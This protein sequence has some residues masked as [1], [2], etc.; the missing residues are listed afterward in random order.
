MFLSSGRVLELTL[1][2][3][4]LIVKKKNYFSLRFKLSSRNNIITYVK[5]CLLCTDINKDEMTA[6]QC[7][8]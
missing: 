2:L 4:I 8:L 1:F 7:Q 6:G 3:K 5:N